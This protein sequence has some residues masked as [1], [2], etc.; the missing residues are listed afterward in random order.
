VEFLWVRDFTDLTW[1]IE[2]NRRLR[3]AVL[4]EA[5]REAVRAI[6]RVRVNDGKREDPRALDA[7]A[8][9]WTQKWYDFEPGTDNIEK[10]QIV[11]VAFRLRS[12]EID[13]LE[14]QIAACESR[15]NKVLREMESRRDRLEARS[16]LIQLARRAQ[17]FFNS[18][19][20]GVTVEEF[21]MQRSRRRAHLLPT[22]KGPTRRPR[23]RTG[24]DQE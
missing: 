23:K 7:I 19:T 9:Q 20:A 21:A 13:Q 10:D 17:E 1:E 11:G 15:R 22:R 5:E 6:F 3:T 12:K 18:Q 24:A 14:K 4:E 8:A 16:Q 2:R